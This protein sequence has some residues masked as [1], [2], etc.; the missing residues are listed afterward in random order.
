MIRY[1]LATSEPAV[2]TTVGGRTRRMRPWTDTQLAH[3]S[4]HTHSNHIAQSLPQVPFTNTSG[5]ASLSLV[6]GLEGVPPT[7]HSVVK[8][9]SVT[10]GPIGPPTGEPLSPTHHTTPSHTLNE[11]ALTF[12][13]VG[14][15]AVTLR[16]RSIVFQLVSEL[17]LSL[18]TPAV[19]YRRRRRPVAV[20]HH[21]DHAHVRLA[22]VSAARGR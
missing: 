14:S 20:N 11:A 2:L 10:A 18:T 3:V 13:A 4:F 5:A 22:V 17:R 1:S 12:T 21:G 6:H 15:R 19:S 8:R 9:P 16:S 7:Q